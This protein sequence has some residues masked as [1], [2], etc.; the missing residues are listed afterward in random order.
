[1]QKEI[2]RHLEIWKWDRGKGEGETGGTEAGKAPDRKSP[3]RVEPRMQTM[4]MMG[5][6]HRPHLHSFIQQI[7]TIHLKCSGCWDYPSKLSRTK[8]ILR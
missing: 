8:S 5:S 1:M 7:F 2:T 4:T 3:P 6:L